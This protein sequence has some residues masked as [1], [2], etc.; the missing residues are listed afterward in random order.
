MTGSKKV[1]RAVSFNFKIMAYGNFI[2]DENQ[3]DGIIAGTK[4]RYV[5]ALND[6]GL[7]VVES[8]LV[9]FQTKELI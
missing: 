1:T 4:S 5:K 6:A 9:K 3:M 8:D 2:A 7:T